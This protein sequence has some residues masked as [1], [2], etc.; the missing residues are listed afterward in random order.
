MTRLIAVLGYSEGEREGLHPVCAA[1]LAR[2]QQES[3]PD[4]VVLFSGWRRNET[5]GTEADLMARAWTA[6]A[7][8][9]I[10]DRGARTTL[11][12]VIGVGRAARIVHAD[13]VVLV[14]SSWHGPRAYALARAALLGSH[15]ALRVVTTDEPGTPARALRE[16]LAWTLVPLLALVGAR[17]R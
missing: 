9:R 3:R 2:A 13:E 17:T 6:P 5:S 10:V 8:A 15:T 11:G 12:N 4:D 7:R 14:T 1:R 16:L